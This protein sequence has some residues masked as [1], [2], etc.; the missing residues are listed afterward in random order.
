MKRLIFPALFGILTFTTHAAVE[1]NGIAAR[2]NGKVITKKEVAI[3]MQPRIMAIQ[4]QV[5]SG[6]P[7][8]PKQTNESLKKAE[9]EILQELIDNKLI[10]SELE[11]R[12]AALPDHVVEQDVQRVIKEIYGGSEKKFRADLKKAGT[13]WA[14]YKELQKD[15]IL[16]QAFKGQTIGQVATPTEAELEAERQKIRELPA[17]RD[18]AKDKVTFEKIYI[19]RIKEIRDRET[20]KTTP[21]DPKEQEKLSETVMTK[22]KDGGDFATIAKEYSDDS[23]AQEGGLSEPTLREDLNADF[24]ALMFDSPVGELVGPI[25]DRAINRETEEVV[26]RG[27]TILRVKNIELGPAKPMKELRAALGGRVIAQKR[28]AKFERWIAP[29]RKTAIIHK[30]M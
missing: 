7:L 28:R 26:I 21:L 3:M 5:K 15:K 17:G 12:Q 2:V 22:L 4:A 18:F 16:V 25:P 9:Q 13:T 23:Y 11:S 19:M 30:T 20:G 27:Y 29:K 10:L 24:A 6:I 14:K 1:I 8:S